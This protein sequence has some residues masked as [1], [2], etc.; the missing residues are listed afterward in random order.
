MFHILEVASGVVL[1][2]MVI[3]APWMLGT[4]THE[5]IWVLNGMGYLLGVL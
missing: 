1:L 4:T 5:T 3:L 2:L